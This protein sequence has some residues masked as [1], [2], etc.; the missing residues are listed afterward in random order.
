M[1]F[2]VVPDKFRKF[3]NEQI[4]LPIRSTSKSAGYDFFS[5]ED[6]VLEPGENHTFWTDI[7]INLVWSQFLMIVPRSSLAIFKNV[8]VTNS[9]GIVDADYYNNV[10]NGGNIGISLLNRGNKS[11]IINKG[12]RI[13]QG[14]ILE[15]KR[16]LNE[17]ETRNKRKGGFGSTGD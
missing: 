6:Y 8:T 14:I 15:Y 17:E 11:I 2:E 5:N 4:K 7:R 1:I 3:P 9:P 10:S 13:A 12:E 16:V